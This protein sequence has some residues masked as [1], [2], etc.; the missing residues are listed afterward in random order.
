MTEEPRK[1]LIICEHGVR[2]LEP[3]E[4]KELKGMTEIFSESYDETI[5]RLDELIK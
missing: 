1:V 2:E 3:E 5:K 4:V